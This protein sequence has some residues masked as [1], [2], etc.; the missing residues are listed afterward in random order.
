MSKPIVGI[1]GNFQSEEAGRPEGGQRLNVSNAYV[2]SVIR[3]GGV[4]LVIP[5]TWNDEVVV[6]AVQAMDGLIV[7]GGVDVNPLEYGEE[8]TLKQG[9]FC[10]ERDHTD[11]CAIR[12]ASRLHRP[13]LGICR[14]IQALNVAFGGTLYQDVSLKSGSPALK[15]FQE[16]APNAPCHTVHVRA[17]SCLHSLLG[18]TVRVNSFH[19]QAVHRVAAGFRISATATDGIIEEIEQESNEFVVGI[20]WHPEL[21]AAYGDR[22]MQGIFDLFVNACAKK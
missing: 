21:M 5:L 6:T 16:A 11:F 12:N 19:H 17:E 3:A 13:I 1:M 18:D 2:V 7:T 8:P 20:Q 15:H 9:F 4:P 14:G 22:T 10:A